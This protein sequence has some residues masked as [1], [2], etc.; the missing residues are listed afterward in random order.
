M[1]KWDTYIFFVAFVTSYTIWKN[2][3]EI[4]NIVMGSATSCSSRQHRVPVGHVVLVSGRVMDDLPVY[5]LADHVTI[6]W[7]RRR[8]RW[9]QAYVKSI[10]RTVTSSAEVPGCR[11]QFL[12]GR[13]K[14]R[15]FPCT[16]YAYWIGQYIQGSDMQCCKPLRVIFSTFYNPVPN[17][18]C[19]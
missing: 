12:Q 1:L 9:R 10:Y 16:W 13:K 8:R 18:L 19:Y 5:V 2:C 3:C 15:F 6:L 7:W 4:G 14:S 11:N 17:V